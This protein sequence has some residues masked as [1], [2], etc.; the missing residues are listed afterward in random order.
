M[1]NKGIERTIFKFF[2]VLIFILFER[3][4]QKM[5]LLVNFLMHS[6]ARTGQAIAKGQELIL[7]LSQSGYL[8][9]KTRKY[10]EQLKS[11][12]IEHLSS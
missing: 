11:V 5:I 4:E 12:Q 9:M 10:S 8:I 2:Y 3:Q 1:R 6:A 7:D